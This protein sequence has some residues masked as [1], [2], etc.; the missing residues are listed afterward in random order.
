MERGKFLES[1]ERHSRGA[2][3]IFRAGERTRVSRLVTEGSL[4]E[5]AERKTL[6]RKTEK[7]EET[8]LGR[9]GYQEPE[10]KGLQVLFQG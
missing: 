5:R 7:S 3:W 10:E 9:G 6:G 4:T 2:S 8:V 1:L